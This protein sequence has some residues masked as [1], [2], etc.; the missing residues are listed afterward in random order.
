MKHLTLSHRTLQ[1]LQFFA[2]EKSAAEK[3]HNQHVAETYEKNSTVK[4]WQSEHAKFFQCK[5]W[6]DTA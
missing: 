3:I 4:I 6:A 5:I 2:R 1:H